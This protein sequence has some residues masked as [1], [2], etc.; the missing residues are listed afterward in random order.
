MSKRKTALVVAFV[1]VGVAMLGLVA[2]VYAKYISQITKTGEA[3]VAKWAFTEKNTTGTVSCDPTKTYTAATLVNGKIA[4][5]TEGECQIAI[6]N[7]DTEVGIE[8][9]I[10]LPASVTG[11]PTNLKFYKDS[12]YT[13]EMTSS[14]PI[15]GTMAPGA[16]SSTVSV[17]WK[18]A[19]QDG[20][21][22]Y[23]TADTTDGI[24]AGTMSVE[25]AVTGTQ[26]QPAE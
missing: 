17:Y 10:E 23:D 20:T 14:S 19:Y 22:A 25:F 26:L 3:T 16:T 12:S 2:A 24:S 5:G 15:T 6:S 8:Y 7:E 4:P 1:V 11:K 13:T 18:W 21:T 9:K